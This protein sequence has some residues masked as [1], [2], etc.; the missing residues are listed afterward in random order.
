MLRFHLIFYSF[1][2]FSGSG[3]PVASSHRLL[4]HGIFSDCSALSAKK[5]Q[6]LLLTSTYY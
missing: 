3:H 6:A 4:C 5:F 2:S 1:P